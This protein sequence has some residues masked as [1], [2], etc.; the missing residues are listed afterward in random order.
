MG[1]G[2]EEAGAGEAVAGAA[3]SGAATGLADSSMSASSP[4]FEA[5]TTASTVDTST[6]ASPGVGNNFSQD[7]M[8]NLNSIRSKYGGYGSQNSQGHT[9]PAQMPTYSPMNILA[10]APQTSSNYQNL[11]AYLKGQ[12]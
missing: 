2:F 3:D 7:F 5:P 10:E 1:A 4:G 6:A 9:A 12:K 11:M 8:D